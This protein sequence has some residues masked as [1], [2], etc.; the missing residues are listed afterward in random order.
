MTRTGRPRRD[1]KQVRNAF[2]NGALI[3][4]WPLL[5]VVDTPDASTASEQLFL[6]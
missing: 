5:C 1:L 6:P 3:H 2:D 4:P